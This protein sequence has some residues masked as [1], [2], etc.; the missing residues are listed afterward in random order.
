[1]SDSPKPLRSLCVFC[2]SSKGNH[3]KFAEAAWKTGKLLAKEN[4][5]LVFGGGQVGLMG[6]VA[7]SVMKHG[8]K[9]IGV[10]PTFLSRKEIAHDGLTE[11]IVVDTMHQR[12]Q[13][14]ADLSDGF[15]TLPGGMGT[16][17]EL[18]EVLTWAQLGLH[19]KP[20]GILN[21]KEYYKPLLRFLDEMVDARFSLK[22]NR[23]L[24]VTDEE[25]E[26]L[27]EKMRAYIAPEKPKWLDREQV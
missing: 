8:G 17:E 19:K 27:L 14:M 6:V 18:S 26:S 1:M 24:L 3:D 2:G 21:V 20:I 4:I 22:E 13:R 23:D 5:T 25:P 15:I 11:M 7:D 10:I 9:A 12:K 16:L